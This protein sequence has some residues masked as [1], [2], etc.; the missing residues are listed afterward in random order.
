M[1]DKM[2]ADEAR[3]I[4]DAVIGEDVY[5]AWT[6]WCDETKEV[7]YAHEEVTTARHIIALGL[8][9]CEVFKP[10]TYDEVSPT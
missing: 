7:V 5:Q 3:T 4:M 9:E 8:D 6:G 10:P 2:T 1:T